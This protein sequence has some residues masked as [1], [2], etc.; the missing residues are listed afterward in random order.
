MSACQPYRPCLQR[1]VLPPRVSEVMGVMHW[2]CYVFDDTGKHAL[3][4]AGHAP[5][6][7]PALGASQPE[8]VAC[9]HSECAAAGCKSG[10][11]VMRAAGVFGSGA[12][13]A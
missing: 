12:R 9:H 8:G 6:P 5:V 7:W 4:P 1:S 13:L 10:Q 3:C 2:K 11:C